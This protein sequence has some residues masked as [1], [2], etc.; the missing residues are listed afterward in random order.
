MQAQHRVRGLQDVM[1]QKRQ[2]RLRA[3]NELANL[4]RERERIT[5]ERENWQKKIDR[6]DVRLVEIGEM[7]KTLQQSLVEEDRALEDRAGRK[8][9]S[10]KVSASRKRPEGEPEDEVTI[11][12]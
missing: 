10:R 7:E 3:L 1:N 5:K 11:R 4:E 2:S 12:Y 6:I 8:K 9:R